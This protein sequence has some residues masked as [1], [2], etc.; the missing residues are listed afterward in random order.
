[1][2]VA[3][4][5]KK[6]VA[7]KKQSG[8][9][10]A[11]SGASATQF[12]RTNSV[13]KADRDS[14][15]GEEILTHHMDTGANYGLQKADGVGN[16]QLSAGTYQLL[17]AAFLERD[18]ASV[19]AISSLSLTIAASG[20]DWTITRG[21]GDFMADG[22]KIGQVVRLTGG[23][24]SAGNVG[25]NLWV[26]ALTATIATVKV[27]NGN[28]LTAEGPIAS[29]TMT[30]TGKTTYTP[31]TSHT[32]DYFSVEEWYS[33]IS[34]SEL[35]TDMKVGGFTLNMPATGNITGNFNFVGLGRTTN[36]SANFSSPTLTTTGTMAAIN[37]FISIN[38]TVQTALTGF[39]ITADKSAQNAGAVIGSNTGIEVSTGRIKVS[40]TIT[41]LFDSTTIRDLIVNETAVPID[42]VVADDQTDTADV[43]AISLPQVKLFGDAPDDGEKAIVRTYNFV[44]EYYGDGS[45]TGSRLPTIMQIQDTAA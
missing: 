7:F 1:M 29:C 15:S 37:G 38:G 24:L 27:L 14:Y 12:R 31:T 10:S 17:F 36:T 28:S 42:F 19:S 23:S 6:I 8:L 9:G 13:F 3:K 35:F 33:D 30:V 34:K 18:F 16:F 43:I 5:I 32:E 44:A 21:S 40:G 4:G 2:A 25:I 45:T 11:A 26:I 41:A 39:T 22:I 20:S